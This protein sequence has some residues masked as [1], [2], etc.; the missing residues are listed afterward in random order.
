[1]P[2]EQELGTYWLNVTTNEH[3]RFWCFKKKETGNFK[4][5]SPETPFPMDRPV[6]SA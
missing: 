5:K 4:Q 6:G 1:M 3:K 2:E